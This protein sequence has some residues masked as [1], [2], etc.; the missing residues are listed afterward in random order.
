MLKDINRAVRCFEE[1]VNLDPGYALAYVGLADC[2]ISLIFL[3][4]LP[5]DSWLP[6][7]RRAAGAALALDETLAEAHA[8]LGYVEMMAFNWGES[9]RAY[10]RAIRLNPN[11]A[12][13]RSRYALLLALRGKAEASVAEIDQALAIDP[14]SPALRVNAARILYYVRRYE[15]A[16]GQCREALDIEPRF[17]AAHGI[18]SLIYER[19]GRRE[20]ALAEI[21]KAVG[22]MRDDPE[23]LSLLGY[24]CAVTGR[25]REAR[26]VLDRMLRLSEQRYTSPLFIAFVYT[27]LGEK[28]R[29]FEW[30]ERAYEER[31]YIQLLAMSPLFDNLRPD[32][33]FAELLRRIGLAPEGGHVA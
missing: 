1:A 14:L 17:G 24:M 29:A 32:P 7:V 18:L 23:P 16:A 15:R 2:Y 4:A 5:V 3:N 9:E 6:A 27:A 26:R 30:L 20:E 10:A 31:S 28:A 33:R 25:R 8:A 19:L 21:R 11:S 22:M 12:I 13:A